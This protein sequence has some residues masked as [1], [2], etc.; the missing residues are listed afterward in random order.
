MT[1]LIFDTET[2]K[3]HG[4]IIEAAA[5]EIV[6]TKFSSDIPIYPTMFDFNKRYKP[7]EPISIAAMAIHHIVDE[8]LVKCPSFTKFKLPKDDIEY[9]IGHNIDYDIDAIE[10]AGT[11]ASSI[12]R[13]CT[14]SMARY[15]WPHFES[16]TLTALAYQL[17]RDRKATRRGIR[18]AHSALYDCKTTYVLLC[19]IV[20]EK[21]IKSMEELYQFSEMTRTPTHIFYGKYKGQK[22]TDLSTTNIE[23]LLSKTDDIYLINALENELEDRGLIFEIQVPSSKDN[24]MPF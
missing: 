14:L 11:D 24:S 22:I 4:D 23:W 17:S 18:G 2:H 20:R 8:D 12:K 16:H 3:L 5:M 9:L 10:R 6:F 7:S 19:N 21:Q 13:I 15:L 1:A